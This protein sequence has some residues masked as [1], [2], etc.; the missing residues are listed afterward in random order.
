MGLLRRPT[1]GEIVVDGRLS[2]PC[3]PGAHSRASQKTNLRL[4][5][6]STFLPQEFAYSPGLAAHSPP[7]RLVENYLNKSNCLRA[8]RI[9]ED[10]SRS[11]PSA[12]PRRTQAGIESS[13]VSGGVR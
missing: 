2:R 10:E 1:P 4:R 5:R 12:S 6:H 11:A 3:G 13:H 7:V 8:I 9:I